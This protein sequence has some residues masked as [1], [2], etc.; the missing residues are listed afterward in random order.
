MS[1]KKGIVCVVIKP[2]FA[3]L[4][5]LQFL[6]CNCF[7]K[8]ALLLKPSL[9][10]SIT[11]LKICYACHWYNNFNLSIIFCRSKESIRVSK[12]LLQFSQI[13]SS[14]NRFHSQF[15]LIF[16]AFCVTS[17]TIRRYL[18]L[19]YHKH[20]TLIYSVCGFK[21]SSTAFSGWKFFEHVPSRG[22]LDFCCIL[23]NFQ[24]Y[25]KEPNYILS[26]TFNFNV[27]SLRI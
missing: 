19:Q 10:I 6:S 5:V 25:K 23:C 13:E 4:L 12:K 24:H 21:E 8:L 27:L 22:F 15:P 2:P 18:T 20:T 16:A 14:S 7:L 1:I 9:W 3:Y 26:Q 11:S 17:Y